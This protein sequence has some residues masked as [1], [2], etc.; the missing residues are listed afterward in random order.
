MHG[1]GAVRGHDALGTGFFR[2]PQDQ[3]FGGCSVEY[4]GND[5]S[6][7]ARA[8]LL[9]ASQP[10]IQPASIRRLVS[11]LI[12]V[13]IRPQQWSHFTFRQVCAFESSLESCSSAVRRFILPNFHRLFTICAGK[14]GG[15]MIFGIIAII[16]QFALELEDTSM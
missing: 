6:T 4:F 13:N 8:I 9:L 14:S 7:A 15:S 16:V 2:R 5:Q 1:G 12:Y 11:T 3:E 10:T